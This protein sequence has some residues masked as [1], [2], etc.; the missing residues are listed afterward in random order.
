MMNIPQYPDSRP[1]ELEDLPV[2]NQAFKASPPVISEFTFTNLYAW[3]EVYKTQVSQWN[4]FIIIYSD[5]VLQKKFFIP[6]GGGDI[7]D[8]VEEILKNG[9][10]MLFRVPEQIIS[11]FEN[12]SRF[13]IELDVDN[14]DYLFKT[15]DLIELPGKKYDGKRNLIKKFKSF[16]N[17]EYAKIN[18]SHV[19]E[20]FKFEEEWCSMKHCDS[21]EGLFKER[22]AIREMIAN[23]VAFELVG[24]AIR[25]EGR[26]CALAI[27]QGLNHNTLVMHVLK[28]NSNMLGLYQVICNE[29][30]ANEGRAFEYLNF[31]QDLGVEGLRKAKLSYHPV[32]MIKKYTISLK[33][34]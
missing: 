26:I 29:F 34:E 19:D 22:R 20:C 18:C 9:K 12:N 24:G 30:L 3:R 13:Q 4:D 7:K 1:L 5:C 25:V 8:A 28:A 31:E 33:G 21:V 10:N 2:F 14:S 32:E 23:C 27:A 6:I 16:Y 17:Y 11:L 15:A